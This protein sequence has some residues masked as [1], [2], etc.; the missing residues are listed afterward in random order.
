MTSLVRRN[1][2]NWSGQI[3]WPRD[4]LWLNRWS[5]RRQRLQRL[6]GQNEQYVWVEFPHRILLFSFQTL[7]AVPVEWIKINSNVFLFDYC[8][9]I[10]FV[11]FE[12]FKAILNLPARWNM[13]EDREFMRMLNSSMAMYGLNL[14]TVYVFYYFINRIQSADMCRYDI[15]SHTLLLGWVTGWRWLAVHI[16]VDSGQE[17]R[18]LQERRGW[19]HQGGEGLSRRQEVWQ[20]FNHAQWS[21]WFYRIIMSMTLP[22]DS[23]TCRHVSR[24]SIHTIYMSS[25]CCVQLLV[26]KW[27]AAALGTCDKE[28]LSSW[29]L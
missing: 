8:D 9:L 5:A 12:S 14:Y 16:Y 4:N 20:W 29:N 24:N 2:P 7:H 17:C 27:I 11:Y 19:H 28:K 6:L 15:R 26:S 22:V 10:V 23:H 21:G 25:Y 13:V 1:W 18:G 3:E